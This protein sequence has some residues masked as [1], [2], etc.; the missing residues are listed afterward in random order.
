MSPVVRKKAERKKLPA[1][2][3]LLI[4]TIVCVGLMILTFTGGSDNT[5][6][7]DAAGFV[8]VPFQKGI[9]RVGAA[10]VELS[11]ER[12]TLEELRE[13]NKQLQEQ[14]DELER[15]NAQLMQDHYELSSLRELYELDADYSEYEKTGAHIIAA[16]NRDRFNSLIINKGRDDGMEAGMNVIAGA[17]LVGIIVECGKNWSRVNTIISDASKVSASVL[18]SQDHM[19]V[20]GDMEMIRQG[21]ITFSQLTDKDHQVQNGDKVVTSQISDRYLPGILIG[22]IESIDTDSNQLTMSGQIRPVVDFEHLSDVLVI[23][24]KKVALED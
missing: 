11:E 16:G 3:L 9:S 14:I 23:M 4:L 7:Q 19:I 12:R 21:L 8:V 24:K 2:Y 1:K 20:S 10:F 17:G 18:H 6:A 15:E 22:Y 13:E 5:L